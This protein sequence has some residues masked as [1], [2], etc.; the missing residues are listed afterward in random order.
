MLLLATAR[1]DA[2][3]PDTSRPATLFSGR[4]PPPHVLSL[5]P[6][7]GRVCDGTVPKARRSFPRGSGDTSRWFAVPGR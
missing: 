2:A 6:K 3:R 5:S 4:R 7:P 1:P